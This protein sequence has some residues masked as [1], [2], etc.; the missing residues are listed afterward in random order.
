MEKGRP[1]SGVAGA[2][3]LAIA[4]AI[5]IGSTGQEGRER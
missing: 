3:K 1:E 2:S 5:A 4:I